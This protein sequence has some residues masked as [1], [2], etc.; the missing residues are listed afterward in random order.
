M[1]FF[2]CVASGAKEGG[3]VGF[4]KGAGKGAVG[5]LVRPAA[6]IIDLASASFKTIQ[7]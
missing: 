4:F 7:K 3:L 1:I 2:F 5:I 6:G